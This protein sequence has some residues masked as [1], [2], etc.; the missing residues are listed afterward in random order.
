[1]ILALLLSIGGVIGYYVFEQAGALASQVPTLLEPDAVQ[2]IQLPTFLSPLN[3][4]IRRL[5]Q[6]WRETDG[7]VLLETLTSMTMRLLTALGSVFSLL[8]VVVLSF[9]LLKNG[10][11]YI[12]S[13]VQLF[14][15]RHRRAATSF[16][17]DMHQM[18]LH[19]TRAIVLVALATVL[20]YAIAFGIMR[21]PYIV[22][23]A[24]MA[25]PFEFVPLI[26]PPVDRWVLTQLAGPQFRGLGGYP[27]DPAF[28]H[29]FEDLNI[30]IPGCY[31]QFPMVPRAQV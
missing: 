1:L 29:F 30:H 17:G 4:L 18:M 14:P 8:V 13:C 10:E 27:A 5:M 7:K 2:H 19:W 31:E 20:L 26:G 6:S 21:I 23:L 3:A 24:M 16:F 9:L 25:F 15:E 12:H 28:V 22:L 11:S